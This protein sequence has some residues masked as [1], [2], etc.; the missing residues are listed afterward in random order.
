MIYFCWFC[1]IYHGSRKVLWVTFLTYPSI[2]QHHP[3]YFFV[4]YCKFVIALHGTITLALCKLFFYGYWRIIS[5]FVCVFHLGDKVSLYICFRNYF[6]VW[7]YAAYNAYFSFALFV[8]AY[9]SSMLSNLMMLSSNPYLCTY[10]LHYALYF[11]KLY[12]TSM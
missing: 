10:L 1:H 9:P 6:D 3:L 4:L 2:G 12:A 7:M 5:Q 8:C 11:L